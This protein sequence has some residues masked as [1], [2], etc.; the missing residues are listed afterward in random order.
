MK[1]PASKAPRM[2]L[3][4]AATALTVLS[5]LTLVAAPVAHADYHRGGGG[6]GG[7]GTKAPPP[8]N[9]K[10][11]VRNGDLILTGPSGPA[12]LTITPTETGFRILGRGETQ[13]NGASFFDAEGVTRDWKLKFGRSRASEVAV[14]RGADGTPTPRPRNVVFTGGLRSEFGLD[15][16]EISGNLKINMRRTQASRVAV[17]TLVDTS[18]GG[19]LKMAGSSHR[20]QLVAT[21]CTITGATSVLA[22]SPN[23][24]SDIAAGIFARRC[25][26][27]S[28]K[29]TVVRANGALRF[30]D[31]TASGDVNLRGDIDVET[32]GSRFRG[33]VKL[34][35]SPDVQLVTLTDTIFDRTATFSTGKSDDWFQITGCTFGA[36][37]VRSG[38]GNDLLETV[39]VS[40]GPGSRFDGSKGKGDVWTTNGDESA[41]ETLGVETVGPFPAR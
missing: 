4:R 15:G 10:V 11:K 7:G 3:L 16:V 32:T 39:D 31:S 41:L 27:G 21:D 5:A 29:V 37:D 34:T 25:D 30:F 13:I 17:A 23:R 8:P 22:R 28:V 14:E 19:A 26:F 2:R 9:V 20:T 35:A 40:T 38:P 33:G 36:L 6:G 1:S 12:L 24:P 18:V